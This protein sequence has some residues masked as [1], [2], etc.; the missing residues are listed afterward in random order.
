M[1]DSPNMSEKGTEGP[2][3][4]VYGWLLKRLQM[5]KET[6][7]TNVTLKFTLKTVVQLAIGQN[8]KRFNYSMPL[9]G[10]AGMAQ[11]LQELVNS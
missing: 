6:T 11:G 7:R 2:G 10:H 9:L 3:P 4:S 8:N 1:I 5:L